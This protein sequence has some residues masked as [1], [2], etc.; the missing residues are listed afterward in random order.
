MA[1]PLLAIAGALGEIAQHTGLT[2]PVHATMSSLLFNQIETMKIF[3]A[4]KGFSDHPVTLP[5]VDALIQAYIKGWFFWDENGK[6]IPNGGQAFVTGLRRHGVCIGDKGL[7]DPGTVEYE[8]Y[9]K[10]WEAITSSS[11]IRPG[12]KEAFAGRIAGFMTKDEF[13]MMMRRGGAWAKDWEWM[14]PLLCERLTVDQVVD[15]WRRRLLDDGQFKTYMKQLQFGIDSD[16]ELT[17]KLATFV[18][19]PTELIRMVIRD[20]FNP[21]LIQAFGLDQEL[22]QNPDFLEWCKVQGLGPVTI[23]TPEGKEITRDFAKMSWYA[24]WVQPSP[25]QGFQFLHR[26]YDASRYGASPALKDAPPFLRKDLDRLL[27]ASDFSPPFRPWLTG[28]SFNPYTRI[29][30]RRLRKSKIITK[31]D[32]YHNYRASGY[33]D[34]HAHNLTEYV[35]KDMQD[36][37][38]SKVRN[39]YL[40]ENHKAFLLGYLKSD[41]VENNLIDVGFD[42]DEAKGNV[43]V[44]EMEKV[45]RF[46]DTAIKAVKSGVFSGALTLLEAKPQLLQLELDPKDVD[47]YLFLWNLWLSNRR[48]QVS[49]GMVSGWFVDGLIDIQELVS[50]LTKLQFNPADV[51]RMVQAAVL[52]AARRVAKA[53]KEAAAELQKEIDRNLKAAEK[54]RKLLQQQQLALQREREKELKAAQ[55]TAAKRLHEF[56]ASRTDKN[57]IAWYKINEISKDEIRQTLLLRGFSDGDAQRWLDAYTNGKP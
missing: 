17:K 19:H 24:H 31:A 20:A 43:A 6:S 39:G 45:N 36:S 51:T 56:L 2:E 13:E 10:M 14:W 29:D 42:P 3:Y 27:R 8:R 52:Q 4:Q 53:Q 40:R 38:M 54:Q 15:A 23:Q 12:V 28:I 44:F 46:T 16:I 37:L 55:A 57:L 48:K 47:E 21:E 41:E 33:D 18:P 32:V 22:E 5:S 11:W 9:S 35:E 26:F 49:A 7:I 30:V 34:I 25:G 50:R 1:L